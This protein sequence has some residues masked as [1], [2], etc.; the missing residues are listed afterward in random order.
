MGRGARRR[1]IGRKA[2]AR[3]RWASAWRVGLMEVCALACWA[4]SRSVIVMMA[5]STQR[6]ERR[7]LAVTH[8]EQV[9]GARRSCTVAATA[10]EVW[11]QSSTRGGRRRP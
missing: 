7:P 5:G 6:T 8:V 9:D 2:G 11:D 1:E 3:R 4:R 10:G